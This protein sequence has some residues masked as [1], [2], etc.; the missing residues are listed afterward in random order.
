MTSKVT[1]CVL[2]FRSYVI[3]IQSIKNY[4]FSDALII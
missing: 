1:G 2:K 4:D 3:N